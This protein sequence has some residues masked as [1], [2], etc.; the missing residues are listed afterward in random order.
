MNYRRRGVLS[1]AGQ[2]DGPQVALVHFEMSPD[3]IFL[4]GLVTVSVLVVAAAA[5]RSRRQHAVA[6]PNAADACK[7]SATIDDET[8]SS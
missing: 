2:R 1:G 6:H 5:I 3:Q 7:L 8:G 4:A